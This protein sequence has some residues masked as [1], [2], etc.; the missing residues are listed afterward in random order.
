MAESSPLFPSEQPA[1][2]EKSVNGTPSLQGGPGPRREEIPSQGNLRSPFQWKVRPAL[3]IISKPFSSPIPKAYPARQVLGEPS[4]CES[5]ALPRR[6]V[7]AFRAEIQNA[8]EPV[9][10]SRIEATVREAKINFCPS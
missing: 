10:F 2:S 9:S 1:A 6:L 5:A 4:K 7:S 8:R 3:C